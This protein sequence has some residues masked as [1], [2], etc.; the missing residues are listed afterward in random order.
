MPSY[1]CTLGIGM[2]HAGTE[3]RAVLP[4]AVA[5][6]RE[7]TTVEAWD[8]DV[9]RGEARITVRFTAADDDEAF[10]VGAQAQAAVARAADVRSPR[11]TRRRGSRW[12]PVR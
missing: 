3:P 12:Y 7:L 8:L 6:A 9:V 5:A 4:A 1:R 2:L 10:R 11:L